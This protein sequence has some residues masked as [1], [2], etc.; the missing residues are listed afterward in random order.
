MKGTNKDTK[1][2]EERLEHI[3]MHKPSQGSLHI[4]DWKKPS[5]QQVL[6]VEHKLLYNSVLYKLPTSSVNRYLI[7]SIKAS[8]GS[9][10][11]G[12]SSAGLLPSCR[13]NSK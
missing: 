13:I 1:V 11:D 5:D 8:Q 7:R 2:K 10:S 12:F 6:H 3:I 9:F 4:Y